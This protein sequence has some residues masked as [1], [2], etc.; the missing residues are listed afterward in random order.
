VA[1]AIGRSVG[2]A[3]RRNRVRRQ[4]RAILREL[5]GRPDAPLGSGTYL[6]SVRPAV[7][8][9]SFQELRSLVEDAMGQIPAAPD[10]GTEGQG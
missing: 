4:L 3:V 7:T 9:L 8:T 5:A 1:F 2:N 6:L 10:A